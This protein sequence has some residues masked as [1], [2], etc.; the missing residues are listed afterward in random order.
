MKVT[1]FSQGNGVWWLT[2]QSSGAGALG[3][4]ELERM[5]ESVTRSACRG[6]FLVFKGASS[7]WSKPSVRP[8]G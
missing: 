8:Y 3:A 7:R 4:P 2:T 6:F 5:S 1:V